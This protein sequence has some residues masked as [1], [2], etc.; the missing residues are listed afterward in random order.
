MITDVVGF[1]IGAKELKSMG[2]V[3]PC[4]VKDANGDSI[5]A[6]IS[7]IVINTGEVFFYPKNER[8][9]YVTEIIRHGDAETELTVKI[10]KSTH[11][12]PLSIIDGNGEDVTQ[13]VL[14]YGWSGKSGN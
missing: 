4:R 11:K 10:S 9:L 2:I 7:H 12:A 6:D 14:N 5:D 13:R 1:N 3:F 8:G